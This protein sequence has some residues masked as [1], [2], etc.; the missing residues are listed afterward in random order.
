MKLLN[1]REI[2][3][4]YQYYRSHSRAYSR[5]I[6]KYVW[7]T[8]LLVDEGGNFGYIVH[9]LWWLF[10]VWVFEKSDICMTSELLQKYGMKRGLIFWSGW[11]NITPPWK[12]WWRFGYIFSHLYHHSTRSA[13]SIL[14]WDDYS[15]NWSSSA[16]WHRRKIQREIESGTL[17][18]NTHTSLDDFISGYKKSSI[19]HNWRRYNIWRQ[20][21]LSTHFPENIRIYSASIDGKILAGAIFLDDFPTST[22]LIAFQDDPGK[23]HH[24]GLALIDRWFSESQKLG[25]QYLDLDHMRDTLDP[26]SYIGYT[27]FK[28]EIADYE[29]LFREL[30]MKIFFTI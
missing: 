24:L 20:K 17:I 5:Y 10:S 30:W 19:H 28:S 29:I 14:G 22:Y 3:D 12:G 18:I 15:K 4:W 13:F 7:K 11:K 1:R 21:Y 2:P 6:M 25:Y 8:A 27:R 23:S 9:Y 16:R 26:T